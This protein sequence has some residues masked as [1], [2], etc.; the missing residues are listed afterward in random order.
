MNAN[1]I[2]Q[3]D[4]LDLLFEGRNKEYGAYQLRKNYSANLTIALCSTAAFALTIFFSSLFF[5]KK[6]EKVEVKM[7]P[8]ELIDIVYPPK[9]KT[10]EKILEK[11]VVKKVATEDFVTPTIEKDEKVK[12]DEMPPE[13][14][15]LEKALIGTEKIE[16][17]DPGGRIVEQTKAT[18][19]TE[20]VAQVKE[21][22]ELIQDVVE[23][24]A[25]FPGGNKAW[26][27]YV[28]REIERNMDQ[29]Q[30]EDKSGTVV[31]VFV[32]DKEGTVSDVKILPC[33]QVSSSNCV[34][35]DSKLADIA[36][37]AIRKGPK[38]KPAL[39]NGRSVKAYRRQQ[40][41]FRL[42]DE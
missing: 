28:S 15:D 16:G 3:S 41:T 22:P 31:A 29:L 7:S 32:V 38:W 42:N 37:K 27:K 35:T 12:K 40:I 34:G 11:T 19:H 6:T 25:E 10:L 17:E 13:M 23:V 9:E 5:G 4:V 36:L 21:D 1:K 2:L 26:T 24:E 33:S 30:E 8:V 39:R 20:Q 14:S 18:P